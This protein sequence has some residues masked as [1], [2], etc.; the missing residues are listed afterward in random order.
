MPEPPE[1]KTAKALRESK[2]VLAG[3]ERFARS[4]GGPKVETP[5]PPSKPA[6]PVPAKKA[7]DTLAE[8]LAAKREN[9]EQYKA[10]TGEDLKGSFKKGG[11]V[12]ETGAYKLHK[13]EH[14]IPKHAHVRIVIHPPH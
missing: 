7:P 1:D 3:A 10:G 11:T 14:V 2:K 13:G 6:P 5:S 4:V 8:S 12:P 9:V